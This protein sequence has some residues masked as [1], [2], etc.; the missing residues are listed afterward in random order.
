MPG[1][2]MLQNA[3]TSGIFK[4]ISKSLFPRF[5]DGLWGGRSHLD[6]YLGYSEKGITLCKRM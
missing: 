5:M 3:Q 4:V 6:H 2:W 1:L